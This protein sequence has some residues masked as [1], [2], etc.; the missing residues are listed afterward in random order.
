MGCD[1]HE[2]AIVTMGSVETA[3]FILVL[4]VLLPGFGTILAGCLAT[5]KQDTT[6]VN[7]IALGM[8]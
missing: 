6:I 3:K 4:N 8:I 7:N 1:M 5:R 2:D